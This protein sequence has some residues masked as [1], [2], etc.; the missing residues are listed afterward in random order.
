[1]RDRYEK[2]VSFIIAT[3][4]RCAV[5]MRT[6][7]RVAECGLDRCDY[8]IIVV[9]NASTDGTPEAVSSKCDR[10]IRLSRN[11][12]S[13][14]KGYGV[15]GGHGPPYLN[16]ASGRYIVFLDDD[17]YPQ[18][19]SIARMI[20]HFENDPKLGAAGFVVH[21]PDKRKEGG[22]LPDVFL[23]C[24]VGFRAT[25]LRQSGGLDR[26]FFMQAEEYDLSFR[27]AQTGWRVR[28]FD[29]LHVAHLKT[30]HARKSERTTFYDIR[31]N[32]RVAARYLPAP[33]YGVYRTDWLQRYWW[34]AQRDDRLNERTPMRDAAEFE[35]P[36]G[37]K[38]AA[39]E[40]TAQ[41]IN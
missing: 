2:E 36:R 16:G 13:C 3:H 8:E 29:D 23:G 30:P 11:A 5:I 10:L 1:M 4:N 12:G 40:I 17:S 38:P 7:E 33:Y 26:S 31:N 34:L 19:G 25:A 6:L 18:P 24:G 21:L 27:M 15:D 32:L 22:A 20:G 41:E 14:A 9:D 28:M 37:L 39:Q 35:K